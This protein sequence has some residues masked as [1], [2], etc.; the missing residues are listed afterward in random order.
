MKY[1]QGVTSRSIR[2]AILS[3]DADVLGKLRRLL[4]SKVVGLQVDGGKTVSHTK[5]IGLGFT[6]QGFFYCWA[7]AARSCLGFSILL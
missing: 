2:D 4:V 3:R 6:L 1:P 5:V 7:L